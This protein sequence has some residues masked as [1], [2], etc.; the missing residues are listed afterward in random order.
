MLRQALQRVFSAVTPPP[1]SSSPSPD[2]MAIQLQDLPTELL[3]YIASLLPL[4]S[5]AILALSSRSMLAKLGASYFI[6]LKKDT[7]PPVESCFGTYGPDP[8]LSPPQQEREDFLV[9][10][11]RD[12]RDTI[13]CYYCR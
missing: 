3:Q 5:A 9:L 7:L 12:L 11:D 4:S 6:Q 13:Y 2:P 10:L 1:P 8:R